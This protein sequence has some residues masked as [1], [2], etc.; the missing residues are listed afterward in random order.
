M[1]RVLEFIMPRW[2][3]RESV[4]VLAVCTVYWA[5]RIVDPF[6]TEPWHTVVFMLMCLTVFLM[7]FMFV[8]G[9]LRKVPRR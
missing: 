4:F 2:S 5:L 1:Q 7:L 6:V 9:Y 3:F 8:G